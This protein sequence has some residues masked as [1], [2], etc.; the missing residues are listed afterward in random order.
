MNKRLLHHYNNELVHLRQ[1]AAEFAREY[2]KVAARLALDP[3]GKDVC[4]DPFVERLLEGFA[5]LTARIQHKFEADFPRLTEALLETVYPDYIAPLP[6][7]LVAAFEPDLN[8][9]G[10]AEGY[11]VPRNSTVRAKLCPG[12]TTACEFS[13]AHDLILWPLQIAEA[14]YVTRDFDTLGLAEQHRAKAAIRLRFNVTAGLSARQL[15]LDDLV[16]YIRGPG[17]IPYRIYEQVFARTNG[18]FVQSGSGRL[19]NNQALQIENLQPLGFEEDEA[20]LPPSPRTFSGYR[21]LR[22]YF[23]F[24][25]RFLFFRVRGLA[26]ALAGIAGDR[27]DLVLTLNAADNRLENQIDADTFSLFCAPAVNLFHKRLDRV[28]LSHKASE[29]HLVADKSR[30]LD[31][32]IYRVQTVTGIGGSAEEDQKFSPFYFQT[33]RE[34]EAR[35]YFTIH[36]RPRLR[37][38][39]E[40]LKADVSKYAGSEVF[41]SIVDGNQTPWNPELNQ[42][43]VTALCTNRHLPIQ[44]PTG[45]SD[46]PSD[47]RSDPH[48]SDGADLYSE[49]G[50]PIQR[51][52]CLSGPTEPKPAAAAGDQEH[53]GGDLAWRII[54]HL[55]LNY[56]SL[57][58]QTPADGAAA[59]REI[60]RLYTLEGDTH[61]HRQIQGLLSVRAT[62]IVRRISTSGSI[63]FGRG[64]EVE[65]LFRE[66]EFVGSGV[67]LFGAVLNRFIAKYAS[68]NAFTETVIKTSERGEIMRWRAR[69]GTRG[70]L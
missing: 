64:L 70:I 22:E 32:E 62:P 18:I 37:S 69:P 48:A 14:S 16:F 10:L 23:A 58:D 66:A 38:A 50:G 34:L 40:R 59:F 53:L 45:R 2:P 29:Y 26:G 31:Y 21:H 4:Q 15:K 41:I 7:F 52:R 3:D 68:V 35:A 54:S 47:G 6:A 42:L 12:Q 8:D 63:A 44:M 56:L 55:S 25:E 39:R 65:L 13:L 49:L 51:V 61:L 33:D 28:N 11:P 57:L 30:P 67:F 17:D 19:R 36:R 9:G 24:P 43:A 46:G 27:F 5:F 20:L 1:S 60:L